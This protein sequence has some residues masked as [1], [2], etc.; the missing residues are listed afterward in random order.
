MRRRVTGL[1]QPGVALAMLAA[2]AAPHAFAG[3]KKP[4]Q[5]ET[6]GEAFV[7]E[8]LLAPICLD[9]SFPIRVTTE[10][11]PLDGTLQ[12][13][14]DVKGRLSGELSLPGS[15]LAVK[16]EVKYGSG[17]HSVQMT[18]SAGKKD[19]LTLRGDY[20]AGDFEG[21]AKAK[22]AAAPGATSFSIDLAGARPTLAAL[23]AVVSTAKKGKLGGTGTV[24][25]CGGPVP[26]KV[27]GRDGKSYSVTFKGKG[28]RFK[29][30]GDHV[31]GSVALSWSAKG[32][33]ASVDEDVVAV[34]TVLAPR[35]L[36]YAE[37]HLLYE[38]E[39]P[40]AP[41]V[42]T[43]TGD[44]AT[45]WSVAPGLPS[46]LSFD[47]ASGTITGEPITESPEQ[48]Y[49]VT[50][51]NLA[52]TTSIALDIAVRRNRMYSL[53]VQ[54]GLADADLRHF[55]NRTQWHV[56]EADLSDIRDRG[57]A[58]FVDDMLD[59]ELGSDAELTATAEELQDDNDPDGI[60]PSTTDVT[61]WWQNIMVNTETPFQEALAFF[62]SDHFAVGNQ[63]ISRGAYMVDY[64]NMYRRDGAGN[65]RDLLLE[66]SRH[67][68][69]LMY[70]SG[71]QNRRGAPN[72]NFARELWELFTLGVDNGYSQDDIVES[73]RAL[74]GWRERSR[75]IENYPVAGRSVTE[76]YME[77]DPSRHDIED[78]QFLGITVDG[79]DLGDDYEAVIDATLAQR[80]PERFICRKLLEYFA[81]NEPPQELVDELGAM[82]RDSGWELKPTLETLFR[83]EAFFSNRARH[84]F[85]KTPVEYGVGF[86]RATGLRVRT[87]TLDSYLT[88]LGMRPTQP[89]VVDGWVSGTAWFSAQAMVDRTNLIEYTVDDTTRQAGWG[90]DVLDIVPPPGQRSAAEIIDALTQRLDVRLDTDERQMLIDY[91]V[92]VR[93]NNGSVTA[94]PL[95]DSNM[96][97]RVRGALYVLAQHPTY[98]VR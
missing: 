7:F 53:D 32:Y 91:M 73:A 69:M 57:L 61:R 43:V 83:S 95:T 37:E 52:G 45:T 20:V 90:I 40:I 79:Q 2:M 29:G 31:P 13:A 67:P 97:Q 84:A 18:A 64:V 28:F 44:A 98:H 87:S 19:R 9:G 1:F 88:N 30:R 93:N 54:K 89:P 49:T 6:G 25:A 36:S 35:S 15:T 66:M 59:F 74:T 92:T 85:V 96:D 51:G 75:Q 62:W 26:L 42:P 16:G 24:T 65:F 48:E 14:T 8:V 4:K 34:D 82:L 76:Y 3:K 56:D 21:T 22:G 23:S 94:S 55:L 72:E 60:T 5:A 86:M 39:E 47:V 10:A 80:E 41:N 63:D 27:S 68:A 58:A 77:F 71:N 17:G 70:L 78:K 38:T 81:M 50:A 46:G 12:V 11:G 33:G